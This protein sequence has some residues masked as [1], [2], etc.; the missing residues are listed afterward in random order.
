MIGAKVG[1]LTGDIGQ[2]RS[3]DTRQAEQGNVHVMGRQGTLARDQAVDARAVSQQRQQRSRAGQDHRAA[4]FLNEGDVANELQRVA[5]ALFGVQQN[6]L[7]LQG[8][9]VPLRPGRTQRGQVLAA[10]TPFILSPTFVEL[11]ELEQS[12]TL[13]LVG[14]GMAG[15]QAQCFIEMRHGLNHFILI[16]RSDSQVVMAGRASRLKLEKGVKMID[17]FVE[18]HLLGEQNAQEIV[19]IGVV[20]A[21]FDKL[22]IGR[23]RFVPVLL[24]FEDLGQA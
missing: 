14:L 1:Y 23:N 7:T 18:I 4:L 9:A 21:G 12:H 15:V 24:S 8:R 2:F 20:G 19:G 11:A 22:A 13:A 16:D 3:Q 10:P 17:G 5:Q 6:R